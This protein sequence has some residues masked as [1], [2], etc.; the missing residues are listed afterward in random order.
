MAVQ[1]ARLLGFAPPEMAVGPLAGRLSARNTTAVQ[2]AALRGLGMQQGPEVAGE[3]LAAWRGLGPGVRREATEVMLA[4]KDRALALLKAL[5][6]GAVAAADLDPTRL[7]SLRESG[8]EE[9]RTRAAAVLG[10]NATKADRQAILDAYRPALDLKGGAEEGRAVFRRVCATC[11]KAEGFGAAVGPDLATVAGR[12]EEDLV[13]HILDPNREV[14]PQYVNYLV[15][16]A[17][18]RSISGIVANESP[19]AIT[20]R[21]A[22]GVEDVV[23]RDQ[24]EEIASAGVSQMPEG[25]EKEVDA[26]AM[27]DL[28]AFIRGLAAAQ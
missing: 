25:L 20:L 24:I 17:D 27:A 5:E 22:E 11:H 26:R 12:T 15:A 28:I 1:C 13:L 8:D 18:G 14:L 9:L 16:T 21:R 19:G 7:K 23:P 3:V 2:L 6:A 4:R 10:R